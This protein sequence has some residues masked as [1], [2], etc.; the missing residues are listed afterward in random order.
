MTSKAKP[1]PKGLDKPSTLAII[2]RMSNLHTRMYRLS[3][4]RLG[5][6]WRIGS[7]ARK[8]VP[9]CL[10]T[11]IGAKSGL[12]RTAPLCYMEDGANVIVVASQGGTPTNPQWYR[13][14]QANPEVTI[15]VGRK[16]RVMR[17]RTA[18]ETERAR[19]WPRLVELYHDYENYQTWT[20]RE[21]PVVICEP[22]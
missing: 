19:L 21:I 6:N 22:A 10:L 17:A 18:S 15:E 16:K 12:P 8:A 7:A 20:E 1:K 14:L 11:T 5:K 13:N 2:K 4:G 9:V 3:G